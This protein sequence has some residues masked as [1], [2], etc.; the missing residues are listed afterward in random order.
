MD[1]G[2]SFL[3]RWIVGKDV[4][5]ARPRYVQRMAKGAPSQDRHAPSLSVDK[6]ALANK[7]F[8]APDGNDTACD[9]GLI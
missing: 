9:R 4:I 2:D 1:P 8:F 3:D 7:F 5:E 6:C